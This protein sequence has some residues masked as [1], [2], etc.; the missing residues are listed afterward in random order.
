M[1]LSVPGRG[2]A[3]GHHQLDLGPVLLLDGDEVPLQRDLQD[4][5]LSRRALGPSVDI[6]A[7][8]QPELSVDVPLAEIRRV[9]EGQSVA[10]HLRLARGG[11]HR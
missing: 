3:A 10:L 6:E 8:L 5:G 9:G 2:L 1:D 7:L 11:S 4:E